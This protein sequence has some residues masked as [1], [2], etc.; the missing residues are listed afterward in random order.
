MA[1]YKTYFDSDILILYFRQTMENTLEVVGHLTNNV[2]EKLSEK[3]AYS[4]QLSKE[5]ENQKPK[6]ERVTKQVLIS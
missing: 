5:I 2:Q 4:L 6:L 1:S 3:Q